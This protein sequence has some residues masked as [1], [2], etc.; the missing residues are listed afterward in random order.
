MR[1]IREGILLAHQ[2]KEKYNGEWYVLSN[3]DMTPVQRSYF[4]D[5]D[6]DDNL[7]DKP[8]VSLYN[9]KDREYSYNKVVEKFDD[10]LFFCLT[11]FSEHR[12]KNNLE[13]FNTFKKLGETIKEK[14]EDVKEIDSYISVSNKHMFTSIKLDKNSDLEVLLKLCDVLN[15]KH[16]I[17]YIDKVF[18]ME[19]DDNEL[20]FTYYTEILTFDTDSILN[21]LNSVGNV[22]KFNL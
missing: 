15:F 22:V 4:Y 3:D 14:Y 1:T 11:D 6:D 2:Y 5:D 21:I 7:K 9:T 10:E 17:G 13:K 20:I 18:N 16:N 19:I 8:F 12:Y